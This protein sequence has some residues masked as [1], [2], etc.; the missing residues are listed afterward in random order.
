MLGDRLY[1]ARL[2][3]GLTLEKIAEILDISYQ[4]YRKFEK[5]IC[6]PK[7]ETLMKIAEMY[8]LSID[9]LLGYTNDK[10]P[11]REDNE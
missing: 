11:L 7:V 8:N 2:E 5:N 1:I 10:K 6:Y 3:S 4:A 9:Y